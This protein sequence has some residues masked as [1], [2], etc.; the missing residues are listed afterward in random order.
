M[1]QADERGDPCERLISVWRR[2]THSSNED[3]SSPAW[4][5][6]RTHFVHT[7]SCLR[8]CRISAECAEGETRDLAERS[9][10]D[11]RVDQRAGKKVKAGPQRGHSRRSAP[12]ALR[13]CAGN[14]KAS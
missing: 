10:A 11:T 6:A 13:R 5:T 8:G 3:A 2:R 7:G 4:R 1:E 14:G 12:R 9:E